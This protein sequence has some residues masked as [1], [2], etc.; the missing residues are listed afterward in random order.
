MK[1]PSRRQVL[2]GAV[3]AVA[4]TLA[5]SR[6][7]GQAQQR[8]PNILWLVSEDNNPFLGCYGD[9]LARTP[10]I[11]AL[12]RRGL[13]YRHAFSAAPV[14]APSRFAILTGVHPESCAPANQ[15]RANAVLPPLLRTYPEYMR[16]AGYYVTNN[17]KTDFNCDADPAKIFDESGPKAHYRSRPAGKPFLAIVNHQSSH[18]S[19]LFPQPQAPAEGAVK[20][21]D[22]RVPAYLPDTPEIRTD[23]AR[24]YNA[25]A[26]MD[27]QI[28]ARIRELED[29]GLADDTIVFYCSDNGGA[30]PRSKRYCYDDGLH[31]A[32]VVA[33]PPKWA[34]LAPAPMG[35]E[36]TA[37]V[38][39][40]DLAPTLLSLAGIPTPAHMQGTAFL[41][42]HAR[43]RGPY[44]FG[45]RNRMDERYDFVRAAT[46]GRFHYIRNYTPHR[47]F[48]HGAY[49]WQARGYQSWE[50]ESLAG[51]LNEAQAR[52][53]KGPRPFEELYDLRSDPDEVNNLAGAPAH[54]DR[55]RAMRKALDDHMV[56]VNDNG[57]IPEGMPPE[58]YLPSRD[59]QAYPLS[60]LM[61]LGARAASRDR[62]HVPDFTSLLGDRDPIVRHWA[63]HGL[64]MLEAG[65]AP[66]RE[67]LAA[68]MRGDAVAQNRVVAAEAVAAIVPSPEAV[69]L[70][71]AIV[72]ATGPWPVRLQALNALTFVGEQARAALPAVKRAATDNQEYVKRAGRYLEAVLEGR[73][74]PSYPVFGG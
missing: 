1:D 51:R 49:E 54:A 20:P 70:L 17:A 32:L 21:A 57:F 63:A 13:L 15:M 45:M 50:R 58:G 74:D 22:V 38:S 62:R 72:D 56:A 23:R 30:L 3:A 59:R 69:A 33:F 6:T 10:N 4:T 5:P 34:H 47:V 18:E 35:T 11:D 16:E 68:M 41:G 37:P 2:R 55:L 25:I 53:F 24:Y 60:R 71:A 65:A 44:A 64:L 66:A 42:S 14:C 19:C 7:P 73:Y 40:V 8:L 9:K 12:A 61:E 67:P 31:C 43:S 48:Q 36:I 52:F 26:V 27:G 28:G 29:A 46:D 39:F